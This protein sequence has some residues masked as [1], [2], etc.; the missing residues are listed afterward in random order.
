[1]EVLGWCWAERSR[2][3][4]SF[5]FRK[6]RHPYVVVEAVRLGRSPCRGFVVSFSL[7]CAVLFVILL[8]YDTVVSFDSAELLMKSRSQ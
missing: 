8:V 2:N 1:M 5:H 4:R 6:F 3:G 7:C